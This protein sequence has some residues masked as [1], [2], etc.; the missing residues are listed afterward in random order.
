MSQNRPKLQRINITQYDVAIS[1][2]S[3]ALDAGFTGSTNDAVLQEM[4]KGVNR[5]REEIHGKGDGTAESARRRLIARYRTAVDAWHSIG[6]SVECGYIIGFEADGAGVGPA[7]ARDLVEIGVD[8]VAFFLLSPLPGAE[9]YARAMRDDLLMERDFNEYFQHRPLI[10]HATLSPEALEHEMKTAVRSM[11]SWPNVLRRLAGG[12]FGIGRRRTRT[13]WTYFKRQLGY[14]LMLSA[15]MYTYVE[16]GLLR[17][18]GKASWGRE[19]VSDADARRVFLGAQFE[20]RPSGL[21]DAMR[22]DASMES[23]PVLSGNAGAAYATLPP[24]RAARA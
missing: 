1:A 19:A 2:T 8:V 21:S 4:R 5:D 24:A 7:A 14:R 10:Y 17:R 13:P 6:A 9:D 11:W 3:R 22:D 23:L 15:G 18:H 12:T 16:G 20:P